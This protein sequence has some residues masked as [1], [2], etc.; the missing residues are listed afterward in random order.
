MTTRRRLAWV[1][2]LATLPA[3]AGCGGHL[4]PS[5]GRSRSTAVNGTALFADRLRAEG[6][7][8]RAAVRLT[9]ELRDWADVVVRFAPEPGPP[10]KDEAAW[11]RTW[12]AREPGRRLLYVPRDYDATGE[13]WSR[14]LDDLPEG[15]TGRTRER[16]SEARDEAEKWVSRLP[17]PVIDKKKDDP[18]RPLFEVK[19][20]KPATVCK[21]LAGPWAKGLDPEK[22]AITRHE[23]LKKEG[24]DVL[25]SGDDEPLAV[26]WEQDGGGRVLV[27]DGGTFLLNLP[28]LN[29][30]RRPLV[31]RAA[32][33]VG[34][35]YDD[36][37][38]DDPE[39][40]ETEPKRVAFVEGGFVSAEAMSTPSLF[41]LLQVPPF[42]RVAAQVLALALAAC[43]ALAPRLGRAR[44]EPPSGAD[45][46]VAH[47]E[48]LGSLLSRTG[49]A[50]EARAILD[51]YRHWRG[52]GAGGPP[53]GRPPRGRDIA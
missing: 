19:Q 33:W 32:D 51:A 5:Y 10:P 42:G 52:G 4:D 31:D 2:T 47:P 6:H 14:A 36:E 18:G 9:D 28:A 7:E 43:L 3:A 44:P 34:A 15:A 25:L 46:P 8:V 16:I 27:A 11:Y 48:A 53:R 22:A 13:Y 50:G 49:R 35:G 20:G 1:L 17:T 41:D 26:A 30:A 45:R 12:L 39:S 29:P 23:T 37:D 24:A 38:G 21:T 40:L